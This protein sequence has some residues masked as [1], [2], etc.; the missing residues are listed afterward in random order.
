MPRARY[1]VAA[2]PQYWDTTYLWV[3]ALQGRVM[4]KFKTWAEASNF[5]LWRNEDLDEA[6]AEAERA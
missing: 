2:N 3:V 4:A 6:E 1:T 5:A